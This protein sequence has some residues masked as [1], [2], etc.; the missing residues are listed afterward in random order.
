L[1]G[2][3]PATGHCRGAMRFCLGA[4]AHCLGTTEHCHRAKPQC[5]GTTSHCHGTKP[6]CHGAKSHCH[7]TKSFW[8][9]A[10]SHCRRTKPRW[11][12]AMAHCPGAMA[13]CRAVFSRPGAAGA[14]GTGHFTP[15]GSGELEGPW[16]DPFT[17]IASQAKGRA[18]TFLPSARPRCPRERNG[19]RKARPSRLG[20][21]AVRA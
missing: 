6:F 1:A 15:N 13:R 9:R 18:S 3:R 12:R 7:G 21:S 8:Q 14:P 11:H 2:K 19:P 20:E 17:K 10:K 4:T 16:S 5:H